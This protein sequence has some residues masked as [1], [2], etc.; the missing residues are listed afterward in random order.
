MKTLKSRVKSI[1]PQW[2][3]QGYVRKPGCGRKRVNPQ[4]VTE[5]E[6]WIL[7]ETKKGGKKIT[8]D[9]IKSKALDI[10]N[11]DTFK[12]SKMWMDKF[13]SEYD[14]KFKVQSILQEQG[15]LSKLQEVKF[16]QEQKSR[17]EKESESLETKRLIKKESQEQIKTDLNVKQGFEEKVYVEDFFLDQDPA[18]FFSDSFEI[19]SRQNLSNLF[20]NQNFQETAIKRFLQ[21]TLQ[22]IYYI[23]IRQFQ[24]YIQHLDH[25]AR[26]KNLLQDQ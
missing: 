23:Y 2:F 13:L 6:Q 4:A 26:D 16:K 24:Q 22:Y 8:R 3:N 5:L 10:F 1:I 9:Q 17:H 25:N 20:Q 21:D 14:I 18:N 19:Q 15:C 7:I 12:A 11:T